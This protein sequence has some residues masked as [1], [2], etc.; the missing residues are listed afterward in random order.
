VGA[1]T[2]RPRVLL[3]LTK[4]LRQ[5]SDLN[6]LEKSRSSG[7]DGGNREYQ[8]R[9]GQHPKTK[10]GPCAC[11]CDKQWG[12]TGPPRLGAG[13]SGKKSSGGKNKS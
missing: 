6:L 4:K 10:N 9:V 5:T 12:T 3:F 7:V 11:R 2:G 1:P 13:G 8:G